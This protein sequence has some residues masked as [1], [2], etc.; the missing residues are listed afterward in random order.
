MTGAGCGAISVG[1]VSAAAG[2][3]EAT[4]AG[5][6]GTAEAEEL[7]AGSGEV[8]LASA[9]TGR[10]GGAAQPVSPDDAGGAPPTIS[11]VAITAHG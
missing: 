10:G 6:L 5:L 8:A 1:G 2:E 9:T 4:N 11:T 3:E 7:N